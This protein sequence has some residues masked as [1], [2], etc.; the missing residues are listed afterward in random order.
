M[1]FGAA[2]QYSLS[3][4]L[5]L[6]GSNAFEAVKADA[7]TTLLSSENRKNYN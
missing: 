1:D 3:V 6:T 4:I 5:S 2:L 7:G